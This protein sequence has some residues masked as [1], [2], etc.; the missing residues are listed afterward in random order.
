MAGRENIDRTAPS[1]ASLSRRA[2][3]GLGVGAGLAGAG[4]LTARPSAG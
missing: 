4:V 1:A 3:I 2:F